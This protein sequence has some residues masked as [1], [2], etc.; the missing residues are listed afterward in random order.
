MAWSGAGIEL[1]LQLQPG[2]LP[3]HCTGQQ[4][5]TDQTSCLLPVLALP[6]VVGL[7]TPLIQLTRLA[8]EF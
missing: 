3:R 8:P 6:V 5:T 2:V 4:N 1:Q 7:M